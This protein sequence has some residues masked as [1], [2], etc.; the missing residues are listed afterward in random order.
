MKLYGN[1]KVIKETRVVEV[2]KQISSLKWNIAGMTDERW[3][4]A[5]DHI[6][7]ELW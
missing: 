6:Q 4:K 7:K 2:M 5:A 1:Q 3:T